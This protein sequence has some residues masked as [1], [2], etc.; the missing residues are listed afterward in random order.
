[1]LLIFSCLLSQYTYYVCALNIEY[2]QRKKQKLHV[3]KHFHYMPKMLP[4]NIN[5]DYIRSELDLLIFKIAK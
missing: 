3:G 1:M 4:N 5:N 2:C